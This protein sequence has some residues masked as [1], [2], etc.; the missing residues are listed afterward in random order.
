MRKIT[1]WPLGAAAAA[2][3]LAACSAGPTGGGASAPAPAN[4]DVALVLGVNGSPF[5]EALSCGAQ[6]LRRSSL[7]PRRRASSRTRPRC[8]SS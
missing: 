4:R 8:S 2:L 5:Y 1:L 3:A 7:L 6:R